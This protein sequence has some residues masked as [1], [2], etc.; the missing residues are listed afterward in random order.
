MFRDATRTVTL[1]AAAHAKAPIST[2]SASA[3]RAGEGGTT[4]TELADTLVRDEGLPFR[5]AHGVAA[6]LLKART[7]ASA[8]AAHPALQRG[9][10]A[11]L[12]RS[13][14]YSE[15]RLR[16]IMSPRYFVEVRRTLGGPA[17][18][19]TARALAASRDALDSDRAAWRRARD[20]LLEAERQLGRAG[21]SP[22]SDVRKHYVARDRRLGDH[23]ERALPPATVFQLNAL[24]RLDDSSASILVWIVWQGLTLTKKSN[25]LEGYFLASRSLPWWAVG[26]SVMATQLRAITMIGTTGQGYTDGMRFIQFYYALPLAM[27]ILSVTLVPFFHSASVFTAYEYLER[28][29]DAKTRSLTAFLFLI[30]RGMSCGVGHVGAGVVLSVIIGTNVA[31]TCLL[32]GLPTALYTMFGGVQAVTWTDVSRWS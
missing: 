16:R 29:F 19:E 3:S 24:D 7:R 8:G 1:V 25:E 13:I 2:S 27:L 21:R 9:V 30:S 14:D 5:M 22:V 31:T 11:L 4:L 10:G 23:A 12:G 20:R 18:E 15:E 6:E 32:M 17:P 28:R 26:L